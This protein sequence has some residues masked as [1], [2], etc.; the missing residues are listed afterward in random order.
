MAVTIDRFE[1]VPGAAPAL[2]PPDP[3]GA[4]KGE[5]SAPPPS[6]HDIARSLR[7]EISRHAR[8]RAH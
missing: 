2:A 6:R 4:P 1:I 3:Q 8:V 5:A 7:L